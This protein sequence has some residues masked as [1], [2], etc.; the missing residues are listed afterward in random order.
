MGTHTSRNVVAA[1]MTAATTPTGEMN[2]DVRNMEASVKVLIWS[3]KRAA[4]RSSETQDPGFH[5]GF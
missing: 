1:A 4:A 3:P 2:P 5:G